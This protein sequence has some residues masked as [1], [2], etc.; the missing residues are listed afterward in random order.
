MKSA[1]Q[2]TTAGAVCAVLDMLADEKLPQTGF[3]R[4]EDIPLADVLANRFGR[5]Y[6]PEQ[7]VL[8]AAE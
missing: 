1:I 6:A 2:I 8:R 4:Q 3:I 7:Q 5:F